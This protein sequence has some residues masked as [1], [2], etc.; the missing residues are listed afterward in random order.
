MT[1]WMFTI[2]GK[3]A[4]IDIFRGCCVLLQ[5]P[6]SKKS[7]KIDKLRDFAKKIEKSY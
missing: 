3:I 2:T 1:L 7:I 6:C 5:Q 4:E